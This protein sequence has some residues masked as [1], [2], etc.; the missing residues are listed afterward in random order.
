MPNILFQLFSII[1][2]LV[3][4]VPPTFAEDTKVMRFVTAARADSSLFKLS[5]LTLTEAFKRLGYDFELNSYPQKRSIHLMKLGKVD[6]DAT[7]V[8]NFNRDNE[9]PYYART[10]ESHVKIYFSVYM[11]NPTVKINTWNDLKKGGYRI[12]YLGGVKHIE[13]NLIG[14]IDP[15]K[16][17]IQP[18]SNLNGRR[19]LAHGRIDAYVYANS[20]RATK[21]LAAVDLKNSGVAL[22]GVV[23]S[24]GMFPYF[25]VKHKAMATDLAKKIREIKAEG[26][27]EIY[28]NQVLSPS[29]S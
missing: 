9:H 11:V 27:F 19:Q 16:L 3:F 18:T 6:G 13:Q 23:D 2:C 28:Q 14:L 15:A 20:A 5:R 7:R 12:G 4:L 26:L 21:D 1:T 8:Y 10:D 29:S 25:Q 17:F 24:K 22:A